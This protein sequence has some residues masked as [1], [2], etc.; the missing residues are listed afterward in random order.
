M[1]D[2][3]LR[4]D[5]GLR[6]SQHA[7]SRGYGEL[8]PHWRL[9]SRLGYHGHGLCHLGHS[10]PVVASLTLLH[11]LGEHGFGLRQLGLSTPDTLTVLSWYSTTA[12]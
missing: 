10:G 7:R 6:S 11:S 4:H 5:N 3:Y 8:P 1:E 12:L 9:R 2:V